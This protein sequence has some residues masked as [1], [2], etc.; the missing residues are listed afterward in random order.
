MSRTA[1]PRPGFFFPSAPFKN[2]DISR[3][4]ATG[5]FSD[6]AEIR[7]RELGSYGKGGGMGSQSRASPAIVIREREKRNNDMCHS[8]YPVGAR[9]GFRI[10]KIAIGEADYRTF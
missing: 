5:H 9:F 4:E 1:S 3:A 10:W 2:D 8:S 6:G 7:C